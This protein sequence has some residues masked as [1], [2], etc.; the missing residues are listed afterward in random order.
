MVERVRT[1]GVAARQTLH[2]FW[3]WQELWVGA[4]SVAKALPEQFLSSSFRKSK[5]KYRFWVVES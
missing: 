5:K 3:D 1:L 2:P 4:I